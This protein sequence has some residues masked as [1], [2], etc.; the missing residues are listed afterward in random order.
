MRLI[1]INDHTLKCEVFDCLKSSNWLT[2]ECESPISV[3]IKSCQFRK[4]EDRRNGVTG[5]MVI[6]ATPPQMQMFEWWRWPAL[7]SA[8]DHIKQDQG[9]RIY[10]SC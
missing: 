6:V 9:R 2:S 1:E 8:M 5:S 7:R 10:L 4:A 3:I